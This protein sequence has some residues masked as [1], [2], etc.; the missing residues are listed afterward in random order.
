[1]PA[2]L[3]AVVAAGLVAARLVTLRNTLRANASGGRRLKLL[4]WWGLTVAALLLVI[5]A[6]RPGLTTGAQQ[7]GGTESTAANVN[8][9]L[10][11]D[12]SLDSRVQ[13][14]GVGVARMTG[15]RA[16]I[17]ALLDH[18]PHARF[19]LIT[20]DS[21]PSVDWPLSDDVWSL[22]A[23]IAGLE[24]DSDG[25]DVAA[26]RNVLRYQLIS[27][28]QQYPHSRN[29]VFYLGSGA[30]GSQ[31]PQGEFDLDTGSVDGGAVLGYGTST[32]GRPVD[33]PIDE[34]ALQRVAEQL[35]VPYVHRSA[36]RPVTQVTSVVD[37]G[38]HSG[39]VAS[40]GDSRA[41]LYWV[42]TL[43]AAGVL[44]VEMCLTVRDFRRDRLAHRDVTL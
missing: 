25:A 42:F 11:V 39:G 16:D 35:G 43:L 17:A 29:L 19:G 31:A 24:P 2:V 7:A 38:G 1:M 12:L 15:M 14:Y 10:V 3:L 13:D 34:P 28:G 6:A 36:D 8:V 21:R 4:R 33:A 20:F 26:A 27:A 30:G 22:K 9:F 5:A 40:S 18:Y 23:V 41:E 37:V 44:L 32:G